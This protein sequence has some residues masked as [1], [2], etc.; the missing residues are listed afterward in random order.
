M[1]FLYN[2]EEVLKVYEEVK[3]QYGQYLIDV[4]NGKY[5]DALR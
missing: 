1:W 2:V 5:I 3:K 4:L